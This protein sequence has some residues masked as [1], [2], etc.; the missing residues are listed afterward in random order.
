M[1][2]MP[3]AHRAISELNG[4]VLKG[5]YIRVEFSE[6]KQRPSK[7]WLDGIKVKGNR[8]TARLSTGR[9]W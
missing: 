9:G 8:V 4:K 1:D 7:R 3:A 5:R 6:S 2:S